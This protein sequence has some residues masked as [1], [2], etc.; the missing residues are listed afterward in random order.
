M[1]VLPDLVPL[2]QFK[3]GEKP[4]FEKVLLTVKLPA[5]AIY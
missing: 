5:E 1:H 4:F 2:E 3:T